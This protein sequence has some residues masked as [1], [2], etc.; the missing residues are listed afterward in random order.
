MAFVTLSFSDLLR[1]YTARSESYPLLKIGIFSNRNMNLAVA[2]SLVLL[3]A[4]VYT[5]FLNSI[6]DT[7][8]LGWTQWAIVLPLLFIPAIAAEAVKYIVMWR[9]NNRQ[10]KTA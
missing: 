10:Y 6:F 2:S 7:T 1:A 8:P 3:L 5:P 9:A 4:V